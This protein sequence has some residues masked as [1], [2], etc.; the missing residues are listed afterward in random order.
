VEPDA[1]DPAALD[2]E[3]VERV[4]AAAADETAE[5]APPVET[6]EI[7]QPAD[8]SFVGDRPVTTTVTS[9]EALAATS[10]EVSVRVERRGPC[11]MRAILSDRRLS[12]Q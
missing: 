2:G 12:R 11:T 10:R 4:D 5:I 6:A 9:A 7:A 3:P 1:G 8:P